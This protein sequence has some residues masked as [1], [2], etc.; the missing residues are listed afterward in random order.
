MGAGQQQAEGRQYEH[1]RALVCRAVPDMLAE[2]QPEDLE[3]LHLDQ[4]QIQNDQ[5]FL[6]PVCGQR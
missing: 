1:E 4:Y 6:L 2:H 5:R 3:P